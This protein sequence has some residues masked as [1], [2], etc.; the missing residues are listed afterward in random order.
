MCSISELCRE[1]LSLAMLCQPNTSVSSSCTFY[2]HWIL[3]PKSLIG[4][5]S[6]S[7]LRHFVHTQSHHNILIIQLDI[8]KYCSIR[9]QKSCI[10]TTESAV[11]NGKSFNAHW[12]LNLPSTNAK[13]NLLTLVSFIDLDIAFT[14]IF[15]AASTSSSRILW[16]LPNLKQF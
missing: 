10:N 16:N 2:T 11:K 9:T 6:F 12:T 7:M 8:V 3:L 14:Y 4:L 5:F 1:I 13:S 15:I